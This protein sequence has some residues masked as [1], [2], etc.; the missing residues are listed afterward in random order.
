MRCSEL[1]ATREQRRRLLDRSL[2]EAE[3]K[4]ADLDR[5]I[6]ALRAERDDLI[7]KGS[8]EAVAR[9]LAKDFGLPGT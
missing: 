8:A 2:A 1:E 9:Q 6:A 7:P 3:A 5:L 4:R